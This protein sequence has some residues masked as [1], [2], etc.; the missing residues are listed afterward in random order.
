MKAFVQR[1]VF[2]LLALLAARGDGLRG[3][4][5]IVAPNIFQG[6]GDVSLHVK[7]GVVWA[8]I[9][10]SVDTGKTWNARVISADISDINFFN[11][12]YGV[13]GAYDGV[14]LTSDGGQTWRNIFS[15]QHFPSV[16]FG[17]SDSVIY[18]L[19]DWDDKFY[20]TTNMG[21]TWQSTPFGGAEGVSFTLGKDGTIYVFSFPKLGNAPLGWI[22]SSTDAGRTWTSNTGYIDGDS[23]TLIADS[24]DSHRLYLAS[25][26]YVT[27]TDSFS[28]IFVSND[29]GISWQAGFTAPLGVIAGN[30]SA[31]NLAVYA[32]TFDSK[33]VLRSLDRG[34]SWTRIGGPVI[35]WDTRDIVAFD[36]NIVFALGDGG[37]WATYNSGGDSVH[38]SELNGSTLSISPSTIFKS[39]TIGC[40]SITYSIYVQK[41]GC[42]P[43]YVQSWSISGTDSL[44]YRS[45]T[46]SNDSL[47]VT[48]LPNSSG[49]KHGQLIFKISDGSFDTVSLRGYARKEAFSYS[50][51]NNQIFST[52]SIYLCQTSSKA[53]LF[54][55]S[56]ACSYPKVVS[57]NITGP[58]PE[59][60]E[61]TQH[62]DSLT[63]YDSLEV[64]FTPSDSGERTAQ[65]EL[66]LDNGT[67]ITVPLLGYGI[68]SVPLS[69][70]STNESTK[71]IGGDVNVPITVNSL[72][73]PENINL[74]L[75]YDTILQYQGFFDAANVKLDIPGQQW[76]G[77]SKL[78]VPSA[79]SG[80]V[81][82]YARFTVFADTGAKPQVT[83]DSL[84]VLSAT[85]PCEYTLP[86][87]V[88]STITPPSGCG[89]I[90]LSEYLKDGK[91]P[92][93]T[94][95]PNPTMGDVAITSS[96]DLGDA[97]V[98]IYD[99]LGRERADITVTLAKDS[100]VNLSMPDGTGIYY[101][102]VKYA[103]GITSLSVVVS[104]KP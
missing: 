71:T 93:F 3:Q 65:Y 76:P 79:Q 17:T 54:I 89:A 29:A 101:V 85:S 67:T 75:H 50:L 48:F 7:D 21:V 96:L 68:P 60:Y 1:S 41:T 92:T 98:E 13:I 15:G 8:G 14:Y 59:D 43:P 103:A 53:K 95:L 64:T 26:D 5:K 78:N 42:V 35:G 74:I 87:A 72:K 27:R 6:G 32:G 88:T 24:C 82:G 40:D 52:D 39:D 84:D 77:R 99:I 10:Y 91:I 70:S 61:I 4:W 44:S 56:S 102:R 45:G 94:I 100:P 22:N 18:A 12:T 90:I 46:F 28:H 16:A 104:R 23:Y 55:N 57:E 63:G 62:V 36:D 69:L 86:D 33:G 51:S 38:S 11:S 81:A 2:V 34:Q 9:S 58:A 66:T 47:P 73:K 19:S 49:D 83:F 97:E 20:V 25:E 30:I 37:I 31:G 80:V